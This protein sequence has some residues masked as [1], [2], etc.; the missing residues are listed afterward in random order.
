MSQTFFS[1]FSDNFGGDLTENLGCNAV[2]HLLILHM[3]LKVKGLCKWAIEVK[4]KDK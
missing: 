4:I 2:P 1:V 3:T